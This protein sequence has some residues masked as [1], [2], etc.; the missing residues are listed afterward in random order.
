[1]NFGPIT[2]EI[3]WRVWGT[4]ANFKGFTSWQR[5]C[6]VFQLWASAKL[7]G[8]EQRAPPILAGR[9]SRRALAHISN[10]TIVS[11]SYVDSETYTCV[12]RCSLSWVV[13]TYLLQCDVFT[14][15][16]GAIMRIVVYFCSTNTDIWMLVGFDTTCIVKLFIPRYNVSLQ[17][18]LLLL[19]ALLQSCCSL[20]SWDIILAIEHL[21]EGDML[22]DNSRIRQVAD[23]QV[24]D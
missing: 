1:M 19:F 5:Y 3:C 6:T 4:P 20:W 23:C 16:W 13:L 17:L 14:A 2:A 12:H 21:G 8:V 22:L 9:P 15:R 24:A 7:C 11:Y 18:L 10:Y